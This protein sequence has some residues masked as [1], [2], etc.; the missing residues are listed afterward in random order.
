MEQLGVILTAVVGVFSVVAIGAAMRRVGWLTREADASLMRVIVRVL[1][2]ALFF[3]GITGDP[4]F[5]TLAEVSLAPVVGFLAVAAGV[6]VAAIVVRLI[7]HRIG[8]RTPAQRRTFIFCVGMFNYGYVPIPLVAALF[9]DADGTL[10]TLY[11]HNVGVEVAMWTLGLIVLAGRFSIKGLWGIVNP[12]TIAIAVALLLNFTGLAAWI[13]GFVLGAAGMLGRS[14]IPLALLLIG[15]SIIDE[16]PALHPRRAGPTVAVACWLRLGLM[17]V[18][19]LAAA[20]VLRP[21]EPLERVMAIE[22]AMPAAVFPIVLSRLYGGDVPT[23]VRVALGT[24]LVSLVTMPLWITAG[25][26][27]LDVGP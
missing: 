11:L 16:L 8:L 15:A 5:D 10:G 17:P 24:A 1:I 22:A 12:P 6:L 3:A 19:F 2:P 7:G 21:G 4:K 26:G 13:P 9:G 27:L 20:A 25:L 23:A 18:V 14:A